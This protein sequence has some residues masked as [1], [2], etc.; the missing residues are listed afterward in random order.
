M[1]TL[2]ALALA[3]TPSF[4][5]AS[6]AGGTLRYIQGVPV[7]TVTGT[8]DQIGEQF[9]VLA[10]KNAPALDAL[11]DN[12]LK[13][14]GIKSKGFAVL[15]AKRFLPVLPPHLRAELEAASRASGR[16]LDLGL[17][18]NCVYDLSSGMGCS[19]IVVEPAR[20]QTGS[21]IFGRNFDWIPTVG[22]MDHTLLAAFKPAGKHAFL[23][24]TVT[25]NVG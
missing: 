25:P 17:F 10:I 24:I 3:T 7:V 11:F 22:I 8:P 2:L 21:P 18:A 15:A 20:S 4:P 23:I 19:T 16:D 1:T 14:T 13:D 12:F 6:H 5:E 9:G